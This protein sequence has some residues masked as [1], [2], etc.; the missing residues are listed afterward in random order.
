MIALSIARRTPASVSALEIMLRS[1]EGAQ[2]KKFRLAA[3][4]AF[5]CDYGHISTNRGDVVFRHAACGA[6]LKKETARVLDNR[7]SCDRHHISRQKRPLFLDGFDIFASA[8]LLGLVNPAAALGD[9][10]LGKRGEGC[11]ASPLL[12]RGRTVQ[13]LA[14]VY[15][16]RAAEYSRAAQQTD[17]P[18]FR[19]LLL[20]LALQWKLAG[21]QEAKSKDALASLAST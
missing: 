13:T 7:Q 18:V 16:D 17:D 11:R 21:Q 4:T 20:M 10:A 2:S 3:A 6:G 9:E 14:N 1:R 19:R 12:R 15:E 5:S 8:G